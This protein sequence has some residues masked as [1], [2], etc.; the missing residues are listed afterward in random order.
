[1]RKGT[2]AEVSV[3]VAAPPEVVWA[4][5]SDV[6]RMGEWSPEATGA[7][8]KG[9]GGGVLIN[10]SMHQLDAMQ[11]MLGMPSRLRGFSSSAPTTLPPSTTGKPDT[12]S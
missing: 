10:Q 8:W 2:T 7:T 6:T 9:D 12:P 1:M 5:V 4:T 11:W 3:H